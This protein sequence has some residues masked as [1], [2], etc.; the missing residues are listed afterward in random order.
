MPAFADFF[1]ILLK[2]V[3]F[4][5]RRIV[6]TQIIHQQFIVCLDYCLSLLLVIFDQFITRPEIISIKRHSVST[7]L[8]YNGAINYHYMLLNQLN[9]LIRQYTY[10]SLGEPTYVHKIFNKFYFLSQNITI[11][12]ALL[13]DINI[14]Y[15][16]QEN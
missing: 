11:N 5:D 14:L 16:P 12:R 3:L 1:N 7:N 9:F 13:P 8:Q 2:P 15:G 10:P 6:F 4:Y